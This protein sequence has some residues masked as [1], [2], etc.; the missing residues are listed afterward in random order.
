M[1]GTWTGGAPGARGRRDRPGMDGGP[2]T[3]LIV[4]GRE[5]AV[6]PLTAAVVTG[7]GQAVPR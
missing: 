2:V 5:R 4:T 6:P 3:A 1:T 7:R